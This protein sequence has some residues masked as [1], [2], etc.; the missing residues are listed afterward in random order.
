MSDYLTKPIEPAT[1]RAMLERYALPDA[2]PAPATP[3]AAAA[4][5]RA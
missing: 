4:K 1:L 2:A 5:V 3:A